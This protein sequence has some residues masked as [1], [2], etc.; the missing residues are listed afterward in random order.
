MKDSD[1]D[2]DFDSNLEM[3]KGNQIIDAEP[4]STIAT[5]KIQAKDLQEME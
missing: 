1:F 2:P 4:S 3:D 5:T